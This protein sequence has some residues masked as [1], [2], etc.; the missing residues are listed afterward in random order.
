MSSSSAHNVKRNPDMLIVFIEVGDWKRHLP[1]TSMDVGPTE[2]G[3]VGA[4]SIESSP[5]LK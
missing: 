3:E 4:R 5:S 1:H 2:D